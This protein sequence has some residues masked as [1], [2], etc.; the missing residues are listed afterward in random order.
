MRVDHYHLWGKVGGSK[1]KKK[2]PFQAKT[3]CLP[4]ETWSDFLDFSYLKRGLG[5]V[6][7]T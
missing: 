6:L 1:G 4:P 3:K 7:L 5:T 2:N